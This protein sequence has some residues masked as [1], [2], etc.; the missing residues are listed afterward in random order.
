MSNAS[1]H[2]SCSRASAPVEI[3]F[4]CDALLL[5]QLPLWLASKARMH[6][7][8]SHP[9]LSVVHYKGFGKTLD[10]RDG[11]PPADLLRMLA[12]ADVVA[13]DGDWFE[14]AP[15]SD[16]ICVNFVC[17][18]PMLFASSHART[19]PGP[20]LLAFKIED[21]E[22]EFLQSWNGLRCRVG[23]DGLPFKVAA[24]R[25]D[26]AP[27]RVVEIAYVIVPRCVCSPSYRGGILWNGAAA[28]ALPPPRD[29]IFASILDD[30][31]KIDRWESIAELNQSRIA[32]NLPP[33]RD[34]SQLG[35]SPAVSLSPARDALHSPPNAS[36]EDARASLFEAAADAAVHSYFSH[37]HE[38][39]L[40]PGASVFVSLGTLAT[41]ATYHQATSLH[42]A[43]HLQR[44][45]VAWGGYHI[46]ACELAAE[47]ALYMP[48]FP[49]ALPWHY[50]HAIRTRVVGAEVE[51]QQGVLK[52]VQCSGLHCH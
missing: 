13:F 6:D 19:E 23:S 25:P 18:L 7:G 24:D 40:A 44:R 1:F 12:A 20:A 48:N 51:T 29:H 17:A 26:C 28:A 14:V 42:P 15:G 35:R 50:F 39:K 8:R 37:A 3:E 10:I 9:E 16:G 47:S 34:R 27:H 43:I 5:E 49:S 46:V 21:E 30:A 38:D 41:L 4:R 31:K 22:A 33:F 32:S 11:P 45:V 52:G 2:A 36:P